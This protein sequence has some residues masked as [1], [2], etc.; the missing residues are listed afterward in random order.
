VSEKNCRIGSP[1]LASLTPLARPSPTLPGARR[2]AWHT[3]AGIFAYVYNC[4]IFASV[5]MMFSHESLSQGFMF[6]KDML[7]TEEQHEDYCVFPDLLFHDDVRLLA[8]FLRRSSLC[9]SS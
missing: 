2:H 6:L 9:N 4:G 3:T 1:L 8:T 7:V 5:A